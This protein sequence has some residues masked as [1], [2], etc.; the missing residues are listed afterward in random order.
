MS[1]ARNRSV[2]PS[3]APPAADPHFDCER[4]SPA[5]LR[6]LCTV[7][8]E[9]GVADFAIEGPNV[10][11]RLIEDIVARAART[12]DGSPLKPLDRKLSTSADDQDDEDMQ[13]A[14]IERPRLVK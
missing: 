10:R 4:I 5:E 9:M 3:A 13:F 6:A 12:D 1:R 11:V 14:H 2:G 7:A 8:R